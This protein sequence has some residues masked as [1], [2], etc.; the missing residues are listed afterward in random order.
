MARSFRFFE[1]V[2]DCRAEKEHLQ[3]GDETRGNFNQRKLVN[4]G[5]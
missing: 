3:G 4:E 1:Q 5:E 2:R